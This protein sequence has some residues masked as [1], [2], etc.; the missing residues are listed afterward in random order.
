MKDPISPTLI[1]DNSEGSLEDQGYTYNQAGF[2]YNQAGVFYGG[3]YGFSD[4]VPIIAIID[5]AIANLI[6][7]SDIYIPGNPGFTGQPVAPGF[8]MYITH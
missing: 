4:V 8:F 6:S 3:F 2:T 5:N 1:I 7:F